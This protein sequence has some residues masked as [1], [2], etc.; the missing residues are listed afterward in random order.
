MIVERVKRGKGEGDLTVQEAGRRGGRK[1]RDTHGHEFYE[2]IGRMGGRVISEKERGT[3]FFQGIG[4]KGGDSTIARHGPEHMR[5]V[6]KRGGEV[7]KARHDPEYYSRI[8]KIGGRVRADQRRAS[9]DK[10]S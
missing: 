2:R 10:V 3:G 5:N 6:G 9:A 8:G 1:V 7:V 4:K